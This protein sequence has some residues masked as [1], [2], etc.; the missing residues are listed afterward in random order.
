VGTCGL[1]QRIGRSGPVAPGQVS[2]I[3]KGDRMFN[4]DTLHVRGKLAYVKAGRA[5]LIRMDQEDG[6]SPTDD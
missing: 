6:A 3:A 2:M 5:G 4:G 1:R